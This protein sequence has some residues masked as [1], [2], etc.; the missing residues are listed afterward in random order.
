LIAAKNL[1]SRSARFAARMPAAARS[2]CF[3][4]AYGTTKVV[5]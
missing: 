3:S 4:T 2:C 1:V 5:P